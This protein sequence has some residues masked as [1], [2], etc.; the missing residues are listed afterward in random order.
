M[1]LAGCSSWTVKEPPKV[2]TEYKT[3][4][5]PE[6]VVSSPDELTLRDVEFI[7][8]TEDNAEEVFSEVKGDKV[9]FAITVKDYENLALN[10]NDIRS[11]IEQQN[12]I[13]LVYKKVWK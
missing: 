9:L 4:L 2:V 6:P 3:I 11:Y 8:V 7:I 5:P 10:L 1:S 13:I 12:Q